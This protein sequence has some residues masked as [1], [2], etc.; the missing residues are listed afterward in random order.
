MNPHKAARELREFRRVKSISLS[1]SKY[2]FFLFFMK[3]YGYLHFVRAFLTDYITRRAVIFP[4]KPQHLRASCSCEVKETM[5]EDTP[6]V[7]CKSAVLASFPRPAIFGHCSE[8]APSPS[9]AY[10]ICPC[11]HSVFSCRSHLRLF[12]P[13][14][15]YFFPHVFNVPLSTLAT[16]IL[17]APRSVM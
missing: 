4:L 3:Y 7:L 10:S 16:I 8:V 9:T 12:L 14:I 6:R 1:L 13:T 17:N 2:F 5:A 11:P 15:S